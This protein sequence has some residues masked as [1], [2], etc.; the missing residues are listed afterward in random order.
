MIDSQNGHAG[1]VGQGVEPGLGLP[2]RC[3]HGEDGGLVCDVED[4]F[5]D[6]DKG[7][8]GM[9][10]LLYFGHFGRSACAEDDVGDAAFC[11]P[12]CDRAAD[13]TAGA[14]DQHDLSGLGEV[15][16]GRVD[17]GVDIIVEGLSEVVSGMCRALHGSGWCGS[18]W[19]DWKDSGIEVKIEAE[20]SKETRLMKASLYT[21]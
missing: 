5:A 3:G 4:V 8:K 1:V 9:D 11:V 20:M 16:L 6:F 15:G 2:D 12:Q 19:C 10:A 21:P 17:G 14:G 13:A 18:G 7:V